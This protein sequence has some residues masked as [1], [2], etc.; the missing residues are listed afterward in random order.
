M[1][2][3]L[4]AGR[5]GA[6]A[7]VSG[8]RFAPE[9][10]GAAAAV[11]SRRNR[12]RGS[13]SRSRPLESAM[14]SRLS[15]RPYGWCVLSPLFAGCRRRAIVV[16][17]HRA[18]RGIAGASNIAIESSLAASYH[19]GKRHACPSCQLVSNP[20]EREAP[21][22]F[23]ARHK[24]TLTVTPNRAKPT[25]VLHPLLA[26]R[27]PQSR[28]SYFPSSFHCCFP[29]F[30]HKVARQ[31]PQ[32]AHQFICFRCIQPARAREQRDCV[33]RPPHSPPSRSV[34]ALAGNVQ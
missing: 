8:L 31:L 24:L 14:K 5:C 15:L 9:A 28:R 2:R 25:F 1:I 30:S 17:V 22:A 19:G 26:R 6:A 12:R 18:L 20:V 34:G 27:F 4:V 33:H 11:V 23:P 16:V 13:R 3:A 21:H 29:E 32:L 7:C 10:R